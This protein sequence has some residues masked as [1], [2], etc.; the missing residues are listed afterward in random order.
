VTNIVQCL[1]TLEGAILK[2]MG[3]C[4]ITQEYIITNQ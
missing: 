3:V 1:L 2:E 4:G